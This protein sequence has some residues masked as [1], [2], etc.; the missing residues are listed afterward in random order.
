MGKSRKKKKKEGLK[1]NDLNLL[2]ISKLP[3]TLDTA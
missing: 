3:I 1:E 2:L